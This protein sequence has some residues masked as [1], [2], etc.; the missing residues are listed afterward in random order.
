MNLEKRLNSMRRDNKIHLDNDEIVALAKSLEDVQGDVWLFGSR[1]EASRKGGDIDILVL[2][3]GDAF[4]TSQ[5]IATRFFALCE[6]K[7]DVIVF[8]AAAM[9][10]EQQAFF[11]HINKVKLS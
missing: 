9:N 8:D 4:A 5:Q 1:T 7:I 11:T 3:S 2:T 10:A 6:E